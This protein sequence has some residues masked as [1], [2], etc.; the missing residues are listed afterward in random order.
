MNDLPP[1]MPPAVGLRRFHKITMTAAIAFL[2]LLALRYGRLFLRDEEPR[3]A[4]FGVLALVLAGSVLV[5]LR[6][7]ARSADLG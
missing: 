4:L 7:F 1:E 5:Y 2:L 6:R 3:H